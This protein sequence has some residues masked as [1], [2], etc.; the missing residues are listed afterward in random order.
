MEVRF[1]D[2][3]KMLCNKSSRLIVGLE[4]NIYLINLHFMIVWTCYFSGTLLFDLIFEKALRTRLIWIQ[5]WR[6]WSNDTFFLKHQNLMISSTLKAISNIHKALMFFKY[7]NEIDKIWLSS[8]KNEIHLSENFFWICKKNFWSNAIKYKN[9]KCIKNSF[10]YEYWIYYSSNPWKYW[11]IY[12]NLI[13]IWKSIFGGIFA[14]VL[15]PFYV[16]LLQIFFHFGY[17]VQ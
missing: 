15:L 6:R 4:F 3:W 10:G 2:S 5:D 9:P 8:H 12:V 14:T 16:M 17:F 1:F 7:F 11:K 13:L